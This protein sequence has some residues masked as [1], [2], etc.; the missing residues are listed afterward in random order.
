MYLYMFSSWRSLHSESQCQYSGKK[1]F[2]SSG[3]YPAACSNNP[4][5]KIQ[6]DEI[7]FKK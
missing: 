3:A 6:H 2:F 4:N 5:L 1:K 7:H